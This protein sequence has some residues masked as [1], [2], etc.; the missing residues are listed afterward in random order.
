VPRSAPQVAA[1]GGVLYV[2]GGYSSTLEIGANSYLNNNIGGTIMGNLSR[3]NATVNATSP[4]WEYAGGLE[5]Y[6]PPPRYMHTMVELGGLLFVYGGL[7]ARNVT[8]GDMYIF[9]ASASTQV[10]SEHVD[11]AWR[12]INFLQTNAAP[13]GPQQQVFVPAPRSGHA[14]VSVPKR[15]RFADLQG[16]SIYIFG[17]RSSSGRLLGD[18]IEYRYYNS[19]HSTWFNHSG[20][21][22]EPAPRDQFAMAHVLG[23]V[24][25]F[26]GR[27]AVADAHVYTLNVLSNTPVW[28]R[29][30]TFANTPVRRFGHAA[31][32]IETRIY[33][34]GGR[35][36]TSNAVTHDLWQLEARNLSWPLPLLNVSWRDLSALPNAPRSRFYPGFS[37]LTPI[38]TSVFVFGGQN[39]SSG[40]VMEDLHE[41]DTRAVLCPPG[42]RRINRV[43]EACGIGEYKA[44]VEEL[45]CTVCVRVC[46]YVCVQTC[47]KTWHKLLEPGRKKK[48]HI[49]L[50][51]SCTHAQKHGSHTRY[52]VY[53]HVYKF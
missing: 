25:V 15:S 11:G 34:F 44:V 10:D 35:L 12:Q 26:W 24:Y 5:P 45:M 31:V 20:L 53:E 8:Y 7:G 21:P 41:L 36:S 23:T 4:Y 46:I 40:S 13:A 3:I 27:T 18:L 42:F 6:E 50:Y 28:G 52:L 22:N 48:T 19:T 1:V 38:L 2:F 33:V 47:T 17:G 49:F 30:A 37:A 39:A 14:A 16:G 9:N 29:L 51:N 32:S 43:C